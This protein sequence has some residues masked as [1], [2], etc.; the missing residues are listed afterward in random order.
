MPL[1]QVFNVAGGIKMEIGQLEAFERAAREG[2]FTA[3]AEALGLSQPAISTRI[4][5]LEREVGGTLFERGNKQLHLTALGA[6][7]LPHAE[8]MIAS[9]AEAKRAAHLHQK[10]QMGVVSVAA[11]DTLALGMLPSPMARFRNELPSVD[12]ML[13]LRTKQ[14]ILN[15][16]YDGQATVGLTAGPL[17]DKNMRILA[18]FRNPIHLTASPH[19]PLAQQAHITSD[20]IMNYTLYRLTLSPSATALINNLTEQARRRHGGSI[21]K[22]PPIMAVQLLQTGQGIAFLPEALVSNWV[23]RGDLVFLNVVDLPKLSTEPLLVSHVSRTLDAPNLTF[24]KH[25][26][27]SCGHMMIEAEESVL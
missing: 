17:W 20:Q 27:A 7:L 9:L 16:L 11:L 12:F 25:V 6:S 22:L 10:G 5:T 8:R 26:I 14:Q 24:C 1:I 2:S 13:R 15:L 21:I 19:H 23:E 4:A 18:R 3:A